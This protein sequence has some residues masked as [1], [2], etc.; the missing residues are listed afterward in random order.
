MYKLLLFAEKLFN[1]IGKAIVIF[2]S[3]LAAQV[4]VNGLGAGGVLVVLV[5]LA[6]TGS[7]FNTFV[8]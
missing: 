8:D 6:V 3:M 2:F 4:V 7:I 1:N 5:L